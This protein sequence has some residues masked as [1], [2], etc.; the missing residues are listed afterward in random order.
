MLRIEFTSLLGMEL[1]QTGRTSHHPTLFC[2]SSGAV[3]AD[4]QWVGIRDRERKGRV[5]RVRG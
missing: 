2:L 4:W 5:G 1:L 3:P